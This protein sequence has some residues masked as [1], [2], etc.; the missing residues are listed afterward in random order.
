MMG[1]FANLREEN[2]RRNQNAEFCRCLVLS[3]G[4]SCL[5]LPPP[6]LSC[7]VVYV[8]LSFRVP[9]LVLSRQ[10][11]TTQA[12][13]RVHSVLSL[14]RSLARSC[15]LSLLSLSSQIFKLLKRHVDEFSGRATSSVATFAEKF[16]SWFSWEICMYSKVGYRGNKST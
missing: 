13:Q 10:Q 12:R 8:L 9:C 15:S 14:A 1:D 6:C 11:N 3:F 4:L 2:S 5:V 16:D 7:L